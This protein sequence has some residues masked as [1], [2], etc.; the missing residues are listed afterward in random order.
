VRVVQ[1]FAGVQDACVNQV[2]NS[3]DNQ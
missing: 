1:L 2:D 3:R